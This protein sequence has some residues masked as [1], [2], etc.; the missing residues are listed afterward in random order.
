[1]AAAGGWKT[2][3]TLERIY[4]RADPATTLKVILEPRELRA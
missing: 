4:K 2:R 1:V 3:E